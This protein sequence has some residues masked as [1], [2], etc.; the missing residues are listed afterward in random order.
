MSDEFNRY[1]DDYENDIFYQSQG[2][3]ADENFAQLEAAEEAITERNDDIDDGEYAAN[4]ADF[5]ELE[6]DSQEPAN[7]SDSGS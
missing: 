2:N 7:V 6:E 3:Y 4:P 1:N 5:D